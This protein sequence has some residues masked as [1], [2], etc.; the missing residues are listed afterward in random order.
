MKVSNNGR[1]VGDRIKHSRKKLLLAVPLFLALALGEYG[2][3]F[4]SRNANDIPRH[5]WPPGP[6]G[7]PRTVS[8]I[9]AMDMFLNDKPSERGDLTPLKLSQSKSLH[10]WADSRLFSFVNIGARETDFTAEIYIVERTFKNL[11]WNGVSVLSFSIIPMWETGLITNKTVLKN[12]KGEIL[13]SSEQSETLKVY[14]GWIFLPLF[15]WSD[16]ST[17]YDLNRRVILDLY[18]RGLFNV[19]GLIGG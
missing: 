5:E 6:R 3:V 8:L 15:P 14:Y 19:T 12:S 9:V 11:F 17:V 2:C 4:H 7:T 13:G 10:A 18:S 16:H 1:A